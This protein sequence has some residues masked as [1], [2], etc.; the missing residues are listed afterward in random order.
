MVT[1]L[2]RPFGWETQMEGVALVGPG[3]GLSIGVYDETLEER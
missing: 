1:V 3:K 2:A